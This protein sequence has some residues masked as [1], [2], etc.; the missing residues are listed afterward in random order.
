MSIR[1]VKHPAAFLDY[2]AGTKFSG[3]DRM[4]FDFAPPADRIKVIEDL[5]RGKSCLHIGCCDHIPAIREKIQTGE[6]LHGRLTKA[7][8]YCLG[9]DINAE[10]VAI[11]KKESGLDNM[12]IADI[13]NPTPVVEIADRHWDYVVFAEVL[14]HI[15]NPVAFVRTFLETYRGKVD[16][17]VFTVPN[18]FNAGNIRG[19]FSGSETNNTDHRFWFTPFTISKVAYDAGLDPLSIEPACIIKPNPIKRAIL[20]LFPMLASTLIFVGATKQP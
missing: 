12:I 6:W 5:V 16:Y 18:G 4:D 20:A 7:A 17:C 15:G 1:G 11:A 9:V 13:T 8:S 3:M 14:E 19:A 2:L 10:S